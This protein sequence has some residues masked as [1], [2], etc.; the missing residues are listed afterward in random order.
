MVSRPILAIVLT[1]L[2]HFENVSRILMKGDAMVD[3][4]DK[5]TFGRTGSGDTQLDGSVKQPGMAPTIVSA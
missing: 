5:T 4:D 3:S 1:V 2:R